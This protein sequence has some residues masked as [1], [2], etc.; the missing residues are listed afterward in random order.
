MFHFNSTSKAL[1]NSFKPS[2]TISDALSLL[3]VGVCSAR[4]H[5]ISQLIFWPAIGVIPL[6]KPPL[7]SPPLPSATRTTATTPLL[8][9]LATMLM[10]LLCAGSSYTSFSTSHRPHLQAPTS[11]LYLWLPPSAYE[12]VKR[13]KKTLP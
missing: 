13:H 7:L 5:S 4:L 9:F 8:C 12:L 1:K 6:Q 10:L 11:S 2:P 3:R